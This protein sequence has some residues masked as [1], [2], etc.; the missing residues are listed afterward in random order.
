MQKTLDRG[1]KPKKARGIFRIAAKA[2]GKRQGVMLPE[3]QQKNGS[4]PQP[5]EQRRQPQHGTGVKY[6][7]WLP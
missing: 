4:F 3:N 7:A 1:K 2:A 5:V 6:G